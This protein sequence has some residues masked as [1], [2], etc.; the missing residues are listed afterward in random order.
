[1]LL[2]SECSGMCSWLGLASALLVVKLNHDSIDE[3][4][5]NWVPW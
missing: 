1:M 5:L 3:R 4:V 2:D